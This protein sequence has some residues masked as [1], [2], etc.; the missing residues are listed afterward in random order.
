[1][2]LSKSSKTATRVVTTILIEIA[3]NLELLPYLD[4]NLPWREIECWIGDRHTT[5][6]AVNF[7]STPRNLL[8]QKFRFCSVSTG[9]V[10]LDLL[11]SG[12]NKKR[13]GKATTRRMSI[14]DTPGIRSFTHYSDAIHSR[15]Y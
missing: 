10:H 8:E 11:D 12:E 1:V 13:Q 9:L 3:K 14:R 7:S 6:S 15:L 5:H 4:L 2:V